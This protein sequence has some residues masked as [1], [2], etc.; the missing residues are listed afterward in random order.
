MVF[1]NDTY[2]FSGFQETHNYGNNVSLIRFENNNTVKTPKL[3][4]CGEGVIGGDVFLGD[5]GNVSICP[6][7]DCSFDLSVSA[8]WFY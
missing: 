6:E 5:V 3:I 4:C 1:L 8:G 7:D 2:P